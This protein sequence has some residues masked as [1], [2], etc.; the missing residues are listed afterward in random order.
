MKYQVGIISD[1]GYQRTQNEDAYALPGWV[2]CHKKCKHERGYLYP[3]RRQVETNELLFLVADGVGGSERGKAASTLAT[4]TAMETYYTLAQSVSPD[5]RL[6]RAITHTNRAVH[7]FAK[8]TRQK[9]STTLVALLCLGKQ[10][11]VANIGDSRV[12]RIRKG[13]ITLLTQ[14]HSTRDELIRSGRLRAEDGVSVP[15]SRISR[16]VGRDPDVNP[17][18]FKVDIA[19][20]DRFV[21]CT[22]GLTRHVNDDELLR[23]ISESRNPQRAAY[24]LIELAIERGGKDNITVMVIQRASVLSRNLVYTVLRVLALLIL[25]LGLVWAGWLM[26]QNAPVVEA[27]PSF[28]SLFV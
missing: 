16:S 10:G 25:L 24:A 28:S 15:A 13:T 18:I 8:T 9:A 14:D 3:K 1:A 11:F 27:Q 7:A 2:R 12:Y 26:Y 19:P 4:Q 22:D 6:E 23:H 20:R 5:L 21:M 17:D